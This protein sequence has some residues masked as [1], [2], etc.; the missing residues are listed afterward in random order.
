MLKATCFTEEE[1]S[2]AL[3]KVPTDLEMTKNL[4]MSSGC[5]KQRENVK[6]ID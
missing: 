1:Q 4:S 3:A 6:L 5:K 2:K